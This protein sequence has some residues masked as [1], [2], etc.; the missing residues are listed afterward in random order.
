MQTQTQTSLP[1]LKGIAMSSTFAIVAISRHVI[2]GVAY[3][4]NFD[5]ADKIYF[6]Q[7]I[8][9]R[10]IQTLKKLSDMQ[11]FINAVS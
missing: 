9:G 10:K 1:S 5:Q 11:A 6:L 4:L 2:N 3:F 8:E 7:D